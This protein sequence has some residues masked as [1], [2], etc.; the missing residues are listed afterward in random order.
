MAN[1]T[2][3][4][5]GDPVLTQVARE[6]T[7]IDHK[8]VKLAED[9][10]VT[11]YEEPGLGLAAPQ[12]GV[13]KRMFV[14]DLGGDDDLPQ[15]VINPVLQETDGEWEYAEGC[16]SVPGLSWDIIRPKR[17]HI[18]GLDLDGK[19]V[20]VEA[21]ELLARLFQHELDHLDGVLL[22]DHLDDETRKEARKTLR[23]LGMGTPEATA[24]RATGS[25][26]RLP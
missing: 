1:Y 18:T 22:L 9:M 20:S 12:V 3:R 7:D 13:Q 16:L 24:R 15:C 26:L 23:D 4:V 11:L 14:Y 25:G 21:D 5:Y 17:V 19:E 8:L 10:L 2:V 6:V